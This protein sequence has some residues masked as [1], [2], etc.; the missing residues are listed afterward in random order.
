M[1]LPINF[2][3]T[4]SSASFLTSSSSSSTLSL[5][6]NILGQ[7]SEIEDEDSFMETIELSIRTYLPRV[8]QRQPY[9]NSSLGTIH[10]HIKQC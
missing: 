2:N 6:L 1:Q 7:C 10:Q 8:G 3:T 5:L 9:R 4:F